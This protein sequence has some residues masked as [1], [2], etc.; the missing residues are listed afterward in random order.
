MSDDEATSEQQQDWPKTAVKEN[1]IY[2]GD[3]DKLM[4]QASLEEK[5]GEGAKKPKVKETAAEKEKRKKMSS[6]VVVKRVERTKR[7]CVVTITGLENFDV[8]LKKAAKLCAT[9]FACG[10]SV[11]KNPQ[12]QDEIVVQGDVQD[13]I[14]D[15]ILATWPQ[16]PEEQ[17]EMTEG[18]K[19]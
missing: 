5:E 7:K 17:I 3:L 11:T 13:D 6:T 4:E 14:Y 8:D 15:L 12:G 10:A 19:K 1:I 9:K 18:K 2:C 16:V